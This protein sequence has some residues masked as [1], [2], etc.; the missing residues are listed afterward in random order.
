MDGNSAMIVI[1][2]CGL[3]ELALL[4][5]IVKT[6]EYSKAID[7]KVTKILNKLEEKA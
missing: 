2:A 6:Y 3:I 7:A 4:Y 1:A 5:A